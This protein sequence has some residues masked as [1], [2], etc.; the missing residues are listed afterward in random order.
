MVSKNNSI[1][2][3]YLDSLYNVTDFSISYPSEVKLLRSFDGGNS[4]ENPVTIGKTARDCCK[5]A[6]M[7]DRNGEV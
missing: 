6:A 7:V 1:Y 4:F 2:I 5:T 3:S